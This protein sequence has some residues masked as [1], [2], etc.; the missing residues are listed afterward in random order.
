MN[1][2]GFAAA[3]VD[4]IPRRG[5][6]SDTSKAVSD[7]NLAVSLARSVMS[8]SDMMLTAGEAR[9]MSRQLLIALGI[10]EQGAKNGSD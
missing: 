5:F 3:V 4:A 9:V 6:S 7:E 8:R 2:S 10:P 1:A